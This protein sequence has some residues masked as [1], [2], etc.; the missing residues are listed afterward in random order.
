MELVIILARTQSRC[1]CM[2]FAILCP[3]RDSELWKL[4]TYYESLKCILPLRNEN[5]FA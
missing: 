4:L 2:L 5:V 1:K 3:E